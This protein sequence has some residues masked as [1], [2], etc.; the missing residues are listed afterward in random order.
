MKIRAFAKKIVQRSSILR[1]IYGLWCVARYRK[2]LEGFGIVQSQLVHLELGT[3]LFSQ[4]QHDHEAG[5]EQDRE[6]IDQNVQAR[7]R[8]THRLRDLP[9]ELRQQPQHH[10][11]S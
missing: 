8:H 4:E 2:T 5:S 10:R 6:S 3:S 1:S 9:T 7:F 11:G